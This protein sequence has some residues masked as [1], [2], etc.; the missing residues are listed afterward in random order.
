MFRISRSD[1]FVIHRADNLIQPSSVA[2]DGF[3]DEAAAVTPDAHRVGVEAELLGEADGPRSSG[4]EDFGGF[5]G[6]ISNIKY[7]NNIYIYRSLVH[8]PETFKN[9]AVVIANLRERVKQSIITK[10]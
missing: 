10:A 4:P 1:E 5:H 3:E 7:I 9:C 8:K 6:Q 2:V